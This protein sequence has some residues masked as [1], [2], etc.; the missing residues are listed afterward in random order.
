MKKLYFVTNNEDKFKEIQRSIP[1]LEILKL[2]LDEI[3]SLDSKE[4]IKHKLEQ[5]AKV[6]PNHQIIVEDTSL[7]IEGMNGLPGPLV[8]FFETSIGLTGISNF[9][10]KYGDKAIARSLI[11][12]Y[13]R[14][15]TYFFDGE[16][17]G[18]IVSPRGDKDF[19]WG[20]IFVPEG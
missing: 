13:D 1:D 10:E 3:Q 2:N 8:K 9:I 17:I 7:Y 11:G 20:K 6:Y 16:V 14:G 18:K 15:N 4:I 19:G 12:Y 5:A